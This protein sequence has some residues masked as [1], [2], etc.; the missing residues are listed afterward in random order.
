MMLA[1]LVDQVQQIACPLFQA[2]LRKEAC[3]TQMWEHV[4]ALFFSLECDSMT[5]IFEA[6]LYGYRIEGFVILY[7]SS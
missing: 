7:D 4:R 5:Q 1:F 6:L 3:R 2:V